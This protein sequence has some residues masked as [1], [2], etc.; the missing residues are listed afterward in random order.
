MTTTTSPTVAAADVADLGLAALRRARPA[1]L[2]AVLQ[3]VLPWVGHLP[4]APR[5]QFLASVGDALRTSR[6]D[7]AILGAHLRDW[8]ERAQPFA[9]RS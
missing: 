8:Q 1:D 6:D 2:D 5:R 4:P 3:A 9:P 7:G